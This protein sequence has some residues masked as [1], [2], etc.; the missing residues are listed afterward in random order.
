M[1]A[2]KITDSRADRILQVFDD[3]VEKASNASQKLEK[4]CYCLTGTAP[5]CDP[6]RK[7]DPEGLGHD[8]ILSRL[9]SAASTL[10]LHIRTVNAALDHVGKEVGSEVVRQAPLKERIEL[11]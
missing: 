4:V 2:E 9:E 8:C 6:N 1:I 7:E 5:D 3:L 10:S 11:H